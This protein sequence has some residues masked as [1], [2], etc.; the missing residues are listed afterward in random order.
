[1]T[2]AV[3]PA[4]IAGVVEGIVVA[5][6]PVNLGEGEALVGRSKDGHSNQLGVAVRGLGAVIDNG[7]VRV[8]MGDGRP[9]ESCLL[10]RSRILDGG[11]VHK[12]SLS[13]SL[14]VVVLDGEVNG[15]RGREDLRVNVLLSVRIQPSR[16]LL[17]LGGLELGKEGPL[18]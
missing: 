15:R 1:M 5:D 14:V 7:R 8:G 11:R 10:C 2:N 3:L 17:L 4:G 18:V 13:V 12:T 16:R 9:V 6:P